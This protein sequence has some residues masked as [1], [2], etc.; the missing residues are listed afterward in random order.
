M[1]GTDAP[2]RS[3]HFLSVVTGGSVSNR[4]KGDSARPPDAAATSHWNQ[5]TCASRPHGSASS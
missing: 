3:T 2:C 5:S 4:E 1:A